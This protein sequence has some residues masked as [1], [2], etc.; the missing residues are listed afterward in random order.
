MRKIKLEID[1]HSP[2]HALDLKAN[3][4]LSL[5]ET[6]KAL[7]IKQTNKFSVWNI[8]LLPYLFPTLFM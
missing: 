5:S 1:L 8:D 2:Q 7:K 6:S 4:S 3:L